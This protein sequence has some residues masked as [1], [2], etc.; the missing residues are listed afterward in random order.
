MCFSRNHSSVTRGNGHRPALTRTRGSG[1][2]RESSS[3]AEWPTTRGKPERV[4]HST[5]HRSRGHGVFCQLPRASGA[6][7]LRNQDTA[8]EKVPSPGGGNRSSFPN[9]SVTRVV[10]R[11]SCPHS[12]VVLQTRV[13]VGGGGQDRKDMS[14]GDRNVLQPQLSPHVGGMKP[15]VSFLTTLSLSCL[16]LKNGDENSGFVKTK[17]DNA[18][19]A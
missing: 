8:R 17:C 13:T 9:C 4:R 12:Q 7:S 1:C 10:P 2:A 5:D 16:N 3:E 6:Y 14:S 15:W 11:R 19:G 18:S